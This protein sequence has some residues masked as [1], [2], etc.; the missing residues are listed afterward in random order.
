[1]TGKVRIAPGGAGV[2]DA[3]VLLDGQQR[4]LTGQDGSFRLE[5]MQAGLHKLSA[6]AGL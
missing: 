1:V 2:G 5:N 4:A 3:K 6:E